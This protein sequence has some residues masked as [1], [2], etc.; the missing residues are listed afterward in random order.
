VPVTFGNENIE[1]SFSDQSVLVRGYGAFV[2]NNELTMYA[3]SQAANTFASGRKG[4]QPF[5]SE[6]FEWDPETRT[7]SS[8][9]T[10][11]ISF[12]NAIPT[13]SAATGLIYSIGARDLGEEENTWTLEAVDWTTGGSAWFLP[14]GELGRHNSAFAAVQVAEDRTIYYGTFFGLQRIRP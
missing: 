13:M 5:G 9:W 8:E 6:K 10:N 2:V 7:I 11:D 1:R 3:E 14:I 4:V 12:P